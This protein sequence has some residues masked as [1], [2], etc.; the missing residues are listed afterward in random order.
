VAGDLFFSTPGAQVSA[1]LASSSSCSHGAGLCPVPPT[2]PAASSTLL[3]GTLSGR[4]LDPSSCASLAPSLCTARPLLS[5]SLSCRSLLLRLSLS[6]SAAPSLLQ[7]LPWR[8][9]PKLASRAPPQPRISSSHGRSSPF[10]AAM[11]PGACLAVLY[12]QPM[13]FPMVVVPIV[14]LC[15]PVFF[16][17]GLAQLVDAHLVF[18]LD[19]GALARLSGQRPNIAAQAMALVVLDPT[20]Q[21]V[22]RPTASSLALASIASCSFHVQHCSGG[23]PPSVQR[24]S[25]LVGLCF[26]KIS[27]CSNSRSWTSYLRLR[28]SLHIICILCS[29]PNKNP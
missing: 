24:C 6:S 27:R 28:Q 10:P 5:L 1:K 16:T 8:A 14:S 12:F 2:R 15:S 23:R 7:L 25:R 3:S 22:V 26:P 17:L 21:L 18:L 20:I 13:L 4:S 11:F 9:Q 29:S 19:P